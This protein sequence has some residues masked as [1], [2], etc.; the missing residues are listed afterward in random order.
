L[1]GD[2]GSGRETFPTDFVPPDF[3]ALHQPKLEEATNRQRRKRASPDDPPRPALD[4]QD[5]TGDKQPTSMLIRP[6]TASSRVLRHTGSMQA[7]R[8][9]QL[10]RLPTWPIAL[11][12]A[13]RSEL[14]LHP[15][16]F[17]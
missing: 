11:K 15:F 2:G 5:L 13:P 14:H 3:V 10:L 9:A 7:C 16:H 6:I 8:Q 1:L 17:L 12:F 4:V